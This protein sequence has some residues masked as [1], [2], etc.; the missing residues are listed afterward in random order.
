MINDIINK[1]TDAAGD[2]LGNLGS[3]DSVVDAAQEKLSGLGLDTGMID[4]MQAKYDELTAGGIS[5]EEITNK[6]T[7]FATEKGV[8]SGVID[9]VMGMLGKK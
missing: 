2:L 6:M 7:E 1:V 8:P 5:V 4:T 3:V 9:S